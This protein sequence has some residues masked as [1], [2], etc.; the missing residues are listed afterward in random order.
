MTRGKLLHTTREGDTT[1]IAAMG[2]GHLRN[3]INFFLKKCEDAIDLRMID[4]KSAE[5]VTLTF[6]SGR[7]V[8]ASTQRTAA[9]DA[10]LL[11]RLQF[12]LPYVGE[13][14]LRWGTDAPVVTSAFERLTKIK[15]AWQP[16]ATLDMRPLTLV[17]YRHP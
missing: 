2:N 5:R 1:T 9:L 11:R 12:V 13:A 15:G 8:T 16:A 7:T 10:Q 17:S 3:T 14:I 6:K 4:K